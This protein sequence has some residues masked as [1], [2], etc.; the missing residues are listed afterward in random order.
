MPTYSFITSQ[1]RQKKNTRKTNISQCV[2][3]CEY[4]PNPFTILTTVF[5]Y[6]SSS[7]YT[8]NENKNLFRSCYRVWRRIFYQQWN[9]RIAVLLRAQQATV[10]SVE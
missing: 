10:S 5:L 7:A 9:N 1:K 8:W 3:Y 6:H 4:L 2:V